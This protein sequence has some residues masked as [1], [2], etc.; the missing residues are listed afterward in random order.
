MKQLINKCGGRDAFISRLDTFFIK[1][2]YHISNEPGFLT[3]CL[4][5]YAGRHEKTALLVSNLL[6]KH[7]SEEPNGLPGNDDSG[8]KSSWFVFHDIGIYPNAGQDV[9]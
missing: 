7:Y 4:Y 6:K 3:P 8:A 9:Y 5:I 1:K 2:Y